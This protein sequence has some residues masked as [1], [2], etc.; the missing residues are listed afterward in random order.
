MKWHL[1]KQPYKKLGV[2]TIYIMIYCTEQWDIESL[3]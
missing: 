1:T 2:L 3:H